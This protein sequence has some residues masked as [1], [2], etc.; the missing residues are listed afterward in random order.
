MLLHAIEQLADWIDF[1]AI[2][3]LI[4]GLTTAMTLACRAAWAAESGSRL[5]LSASILRSF[6]MTLGQWILVALEVLIVSDI[7]HSIAHRTLDQLAFLAGT[8]VIRVI[9]AFFLDQEVR[10]LERSQLEPDS[11]PI[12][13]DKG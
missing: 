11:T 1:F 8:V 2:G 5:H 3:L 6:R 10:Q 7:L 12:K 4:F 9:L 13:S